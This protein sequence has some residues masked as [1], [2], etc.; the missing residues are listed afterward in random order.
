V[1]SNGPGTIS[2]TAGSDG[3]VSCADADTNNKY[4]CE[5]TTGTTTSTVTCTVK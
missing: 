4:T 5:Y 2:G 1:C 3:Y